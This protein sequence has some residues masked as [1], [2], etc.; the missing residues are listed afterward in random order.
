MSVVFN[1]AKKRLAAGELAPGMGLRQART[2]DVATIARICGF[3]WL[4]IDMEHSSMDV[5][6]AAQ[7]AMAALGAEVTPN[8]D[9]RRIRQ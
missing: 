9:A 1:Q 3:D 7:I 2:V 8:G 5:D 4:F 6:S